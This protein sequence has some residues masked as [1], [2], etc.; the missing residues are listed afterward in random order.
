MIQALAGA[1][2]QQG[3]GILSQFRLIKGT[4]RAWGR[5]GGGGELAAGARPWPVG[6]EEGLAAL[7][8]GTAELLSFFSG[9]QA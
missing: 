9:I 4:W 1:Q 7:P 2:D 5:G 8:Q 6:L 3:P